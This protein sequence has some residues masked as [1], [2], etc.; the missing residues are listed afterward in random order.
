MK[1]LH[2]SFY[3][4]VYKLSTI[5]WQV[6]TKDSFVFTPFF[7][8]FVSFHQKRRPASW[9]SIP[10]LVRTPL[11][12]MQFF[13]SGYSAFFLGFNWLRT[14]PMSVN[15]I[16]ARKNQQIG[17][18]KNTPT[19]PLDFKSAVRKF[20]SAIGPKI[21]PRIAGLVGIF[22]LPISQPITPAISIV[23]TS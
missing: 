11:I 22:T 21:R 5:F 20:F 14:A 17:V 19:F 16:R 23:P 8:I 10:N 15:A 12:F 9:K 3:P 7:I 18:L 6:F 2:E 4:V 13:L 1:F